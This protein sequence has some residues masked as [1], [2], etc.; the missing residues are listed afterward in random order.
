MDK[1]V[2]LN[3]LDK[4]AVL[5][6]L[7]NASKPQGMG[8]V[9]YR[10]EPMTRDDAKRLLDNGQTCFDYL[11]GRVMK[12]N[13]SGEELDVG[14]YDS[15][16]GQGAAARAIESLRSSGETNSELVK[17]VHGSNTRDAA[18]DVKSRLNDRTHY[19]G[20]VIHLGL[21]DVADPLNQ[22][23]DEGLKKLRESEH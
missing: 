17:R 10:P 13:L 8:F 11:K 14:G 23:V 20:R 5:A 9:Q 22:K 15:D 4:A 7:Y 12:V 21:D 3:G 18:R 16:N 6:V 19:S 1:K 2:S